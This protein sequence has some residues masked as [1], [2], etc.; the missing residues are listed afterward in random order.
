LTAEAGKPKNPAIAKTLSQSTVPSPPHWPIAN[1]P[2]K[3]AV[4]T[5]FLEVSRF[6]KAGEGLNFGA[7][8]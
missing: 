2:F 7:L 4:K 6:A 5:A 1:N 3:S 8:Q